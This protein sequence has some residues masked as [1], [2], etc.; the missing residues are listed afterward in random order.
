M[1]SL[2]LDSIEQKYQ[3]RLDNDKSTGKYIAVWNNLMNGKFK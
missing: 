2:F 3:L 1:L